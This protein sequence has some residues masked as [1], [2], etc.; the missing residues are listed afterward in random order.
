MKVEIGRLLFELYY[1]ISSMC[2]KPESR[3]M[4]LR[5]SHLMQEGFACYGRGIRV[6]AAGTS[7]CHPQGGLKKKFDQEPTGQKKRA[8]INT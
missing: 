4:E 8:K 1:L 7:T 5:R 3:T 6:G 2:S